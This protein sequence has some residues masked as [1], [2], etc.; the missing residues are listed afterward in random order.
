[1]VI[2]ETS[3]FTRQVSKLLTDDEYRELQTV[4]INRP[5]AG[6]VII[7]SGDLRKIRWT[8]R[9]KGKRG[10]VRVIY[11]WIELQERILMLYVYP[12]SARDDLTQSQLKVLKKIVEEEYP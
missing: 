12:K 9:G 4:L 10:G 6:P 5:N 8:M 2:V 1:M 7:G 3:V 11:Y